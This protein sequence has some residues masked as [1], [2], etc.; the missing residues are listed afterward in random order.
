MAQEDWRRTAESGTSSEIPVSGFIQLLLLAIHAC[1][2]TGWQ[3][4]SKSAVC[5]SLAARFFCLT[6]L[7]CT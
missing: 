7:S 2:L 5:Y 4:T 1:P 6:H 3:D